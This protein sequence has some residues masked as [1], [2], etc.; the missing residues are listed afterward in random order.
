MYNHIH[1]YLY[2]YEM[3]AITKWSCNLYTKRSKIYIYIYIVSIYLGSSLFL[4]QQS[5]A[6][7]FMNKFMNRSNHTT[8]S[9]AAHDV[10]YCHLT[11]ALDSLI[12]Q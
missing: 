9:A 2:E 8:V 3:K 4:Q 11:S 12:I 6:Y 1:V 10:P 5:A 7:M